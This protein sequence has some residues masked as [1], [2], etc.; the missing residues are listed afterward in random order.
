MIVQHAHEHSTAEMFDKDVRPEMRFDRK[1]SVHVQIHVWVR[2]HVRGA[3][4]WS[5][6]SAITPSINSIAMLSRN[7][8]ILC[9]GRHIHAL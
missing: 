3:D 6:L 8:S 9:A 4:C 5:P 7:A 1:P 2:V